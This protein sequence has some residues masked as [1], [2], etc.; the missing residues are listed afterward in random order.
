MSQ[1]WV[2]LCEAAEVIRHGR[3]VHEVE[4]RYIAVYHVAGSFYAIADECTHDGG[5]LEGAEVEGLEVICP[6]HGARFCLRTGAA[7]S[8]PAYA[9]VAAYPVRTSGDRLEVDL[10]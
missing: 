4:G 10:G 3:A 1:R 8:P 7:L 5:S 6:R 2:G 9:P